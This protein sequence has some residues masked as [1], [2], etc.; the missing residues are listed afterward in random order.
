MSPPLETNTTFALEGFTDN[1]LALNQSF[2]TVVSSAN[3]IVL[4][5]VMER[6]HRERGGESGRGEGREREDTEMREGEG[7]E[8]E[9]DQIMTLHGHHHTCSS[10]IKLIWDSNPNWHHYVT[11]FLLITWIY[12]QLQSVITFPEDFTQ[13]R[14]SDT[15]NPKCAILFSDQLWFH[16]L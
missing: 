2:Q 6:G 4:Q 8:R 15:G 10:Y 3:N 5:Y 9:R 1:W 16:R 11:H 14:V 12:L 7:S 13:V